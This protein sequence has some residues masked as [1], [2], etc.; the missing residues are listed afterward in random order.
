MINKTGGLTN[1]DIYASVKKPSRIEKIRLNRLR[2]FGHVQ[3]M[4]ENR[5]PKRVLYMN[6]GTRLR[7][8]PRSRWQDEVREDG[9]IVGRE[10][11]QEEGHY[12]EKWKKL[13]RRAR[14]RCI[15][16]MPMD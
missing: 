13:L 5:T 8:R 9:R 11:W 4:E 1:R 7:G 12:R 3:R 15:L 10:V 2:W 6:L 14:K 16:H